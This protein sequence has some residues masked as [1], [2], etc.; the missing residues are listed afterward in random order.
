MA[1]TLTQEIYDM[2]VD[3][4]LFLL[5][6]P[7]FD[8]YMQRSDTLDSTS[9][10]IIGTMLNEVPPLYCKLTRH[11]ARFVREY[12]VTPDNEKIDET[13]IFVHGNVSMNLAMNNSILVAVVP[14]YAGFNIVAYAIFT[15]SCIDMTVEKVGKITSLWVEPTYRSNGIGTAMME[16]IRA[17]M[18]EAGC[19]LMTVSVMENNEIARE[20][21][22]GYGFRTFSVM[23]S[24]Q[25]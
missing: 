21:Y 24:K 23:L 10:S 15:T 18:A 8:L 6:K 4:S 1:T 9:R 22:A 13:G 11:E 25:I 3:Y 2:S 16:Q 5:N 20:F 14:T 17:H 19:K 12:G 7:L